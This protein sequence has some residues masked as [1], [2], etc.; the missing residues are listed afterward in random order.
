M[1]KHFGQ[2]RQTRPTSFDFSERLKSSQWD[3]N[4]SGFHEAFI[5]FPVTKLRHPLSF[6]ADL[7]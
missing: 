7:I 6:G 5:Y 4:D 2:N 1:S 3:K